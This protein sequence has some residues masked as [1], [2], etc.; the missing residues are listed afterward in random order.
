MTEVTVLIDLGQMPT[1]TSRPNRTGYRDP[2]CRPTGWCCSAWCSPCWPAAT[3]PV[4]A[5]PLLIR[6]VPNGPNPVFELLD[7]VLYAATSGTVSAYRLADNR[8]LWSQPVTGEVRGLSVQPA[9]GTL[10]VSASTDD[11][12]TEAVFDRAT[13]APLW[14]RANTNLQVLTGGRLVLATSRSN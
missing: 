4:P 3:V 7:G 14:Q 13:G 10:I 9:A 8:P 1:G 6:T 5:G 2:R 11:D 12:T